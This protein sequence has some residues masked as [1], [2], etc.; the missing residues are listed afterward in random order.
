MR[1]VQPA[2]WI[3]NLQQSVQ[4]NLE[5][6]FRKISN[7]TPRRSIQVDY[8]DRISVVTW[9][10]VFGLGASILLD[11]PTAVL[12][13][14][15]LGSPISIPFGERI[16]AAIFMAVLAAAGTQSVVSVHPYFAM[17]RRGG[18]QTWAFWALPSAIT[19][20]A[21]LLLPLAPSRQ[22]GVLALL[23]SGALLAM[24]FFGLYA[25]V[26]RGGPGFRRS[27]F[28]LDALAYG[29]A[30]LL[31]LLVYQTRTRSLLSGSLIAA[32]AMLLAVELLRSTTSDVKLVLGYG[33][34]VGL[35]LG[36]VTWA[37]NY[38]L[39]ANLTGGLLLLLIF[40]LLTG[41]AQQG[42]QGRLNRRVL[43]EFGVFA[44]VAIVLI[45]AV[46]PRFR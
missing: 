3:G 7:T 24:A 39:L 29:S 12:T 8:R 19:I 44:T 22:V 33:M 42:I 23:V 25:T 28:L 4:R 17:N 11:L 40:Y 37:L 36:E 18:A 10:I 35:I 14:R 41:M 21:V 1:N 5:G 9:L 16:V 31:F 20:I 13:F 38:W 45:V 30:L 43:I 32:T 2:N 26:E 6:R 46:G 27:R 34:I 15:A